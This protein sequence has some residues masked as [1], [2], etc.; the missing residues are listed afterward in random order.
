M[1]RVGFV[2]LAATVVLANCSRFIFNPHKEGGEDFEKD[3][4]FEKPDGVVIPAGAGRKECHD[5]LLQGCGRTMLTVCQDE[6]VVESRGG[7]AAIDREMCEESSACITAIKDFLGARDAWYGSDSGDPDELCLDSGFHDVAREVLQADE[8]RMNWWDLGDGCGLIVV[9]ERGGFPT[10]LA[11]QIGLA[12]AGLL[13]MFGFIFGSIMNANQGIREL[14]RSHP[15]PANVSVQYYQGDKH[16][17]PR[18]VFQVPQ[19][20]QAFQASHLPVAVTAVPIEA[21]P[22]QL[23]PGRGPAQVVPGVTCTS[24]GATMSH[25]AKFCPQCGI[26]CSPASAWKPPTAMV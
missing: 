25:N 6:G 15:F 2:I 3:T 12:V 8:I 18:L 1:Q 23:L 21:V 26:K 19:A 24:C 17:P 22:G 16:S 10:W 14:F 20:M 9:D 13:L 4:H 11:L 7:G 5:I